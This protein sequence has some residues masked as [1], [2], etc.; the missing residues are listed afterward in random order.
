VSTEQDGHKA[1]PDQ[2]VVHRAKERINNMN[3]VAHEVT[4]EL[5]KPV[6]EK[7]DVLSVLYTDTKPRQE[8]E[9]G[10]TQPPQPSEQGKAELLPV[11]TPEK[12]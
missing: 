12:R 3:Q 9:T 2:A 5:G 4:T 8:G 10:V 11:P 1:Q 7:Y 6:E